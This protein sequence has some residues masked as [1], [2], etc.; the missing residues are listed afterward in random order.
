MVDSSALRT[1]AANLMMA[2]LA[3]PGLGITAAHAQQAF[4]GTWRPDPQK[5]GPSQKPDTYDLTG[6]LYS[7]SSCE[8]PYQMKADGA[9]HPVPG[10]RYDTLSIKVVDDRTLARTAKKGGQIVAE[11]RATVSA[12]GKSLTEQQTVFGMASHPLELTR[13]SSRVAAPPAGSHQIAGSWRLLETDLTHHDE[14]T[15]YTVNGDT[16]SMTDRMGRSFTA[17][18]DGTDATYEG[19]PHFTSVSV[20]LLNPTTLEES[21]KKDGKVVQVN[22]WS[23]EP[24]GKTMHARF[25][26]THGHI[27]EQTGHKVN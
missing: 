26:D 11:T 13:R 3:L 5:P 1:V 9:D 21:D 10:N 18:V 25:D 22:R 23:I 14:D 16:L 20:K 2:C 12:D 17:K 7:C 6:G 4:S 8:P 27:Q 15:T 24:D 19:D